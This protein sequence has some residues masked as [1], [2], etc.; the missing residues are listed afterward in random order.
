MYEGAVTHLNEIPSRLPNFQLLNKAE[1]NL[2]HSCSSTLYL[3]ACVYD[4]LGTDPTIL[5]V[6]KT[7]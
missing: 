3:Q 4:V 2:P 6:T 7:S 5:W 1:H